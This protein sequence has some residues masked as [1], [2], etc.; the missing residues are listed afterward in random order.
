MPPMLWEGILYALW[1][2]F[3]PAAIVGGS[4][5]RRARV[6]RLGA[7]FVEVTERLRDRVWH[8]LA[9]AGTD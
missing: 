7:A 2:A 5:V 1:V 4:Y 3:A 8:T 9:P 6:K